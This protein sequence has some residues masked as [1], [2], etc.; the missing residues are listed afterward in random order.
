VP[1]S[2]LFKARQ[3]VQRTWERKQPLAT[4]MLAFAAAIRR[5]AAEISGLR[6]SNSD[7]KSG[8]MTGDPE[9]SVPLWNMKGGSILA[10]EHSNGMLELGPL[11]GHS[12]QLSLGGLEQRLGLGDVQVGNPLRRRDDCGLTQGIY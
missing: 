8:G 3:T 9:A 12:R 7:G 10:S 11:Q 4:P 1:A 5:S 6:S 2:I